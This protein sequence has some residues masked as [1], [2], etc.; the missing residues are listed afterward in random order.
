MPAESRSPFV[1]AAL[2]LSLSLP[3][4]GPKPTTPGE[5]RPTGEGASVPVRVA[6]AAP[7]A[8]PQTLRVNGPLVADQQSDVTGVVPGRVVEVLVER[9]SIV[10]EGDPLV[11]LRDVDY[12]LQVAAATAAL[13]Q[14]EARLGV[15][16]PGAAVRAEDTAEVRAAAA[17]DGLARESLR[18]AEQLAQTGAVSQAELD[19]ARAGAAAAHEQYNSA[20][21]GMRGAA[22]A[23][24][25]ARIA[26]QQAGT[27]VRESVVRAPFAGEIAERFADVGEYV[28]PQ[29]RLV[30]LVKTD[31]LRVELPVPQERVGVVQ[32]GQT[33]ALRVDAFPDRVFTGTVRYISASVRPETRSLT[34]E[35]TVPNA[36]GALRPGMF[37]TATIDLGGTRQGVAVPVAAVL[38]EAGVS[39]VFVVKPDGT[40]EERVVSVV[41]SDGATVTVSEGVRAGERLAVETLERLADG[42]RVTAR[43]ATVSQ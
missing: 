7:R 33:V 18:R 27:A 35:A 28:A 29:M 23:L 4:C 13:Q 40:I 19:R 10:A 1:V 12:R 22:I 9:G 41:E 32:R 38:R 24:S 21:N 43:T 30:S 31:P 5:V 6:V 14:A 8:L 20:L 25:Q 39:R 34:V 42:V 16:S 15:T 26:L 36:D 17:N 3:A 37:A 2:F 11:R